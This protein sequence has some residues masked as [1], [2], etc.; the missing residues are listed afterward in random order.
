MPRLELGLCRGCCPHLTSAHTAKDKD[1]LGTPILTEPEPWL[2]PGLHARAR[3][4]T[5]HAQH[6]HTHAGREHA[7]DSPDCRP[8]SLL[9]APRA[10]RGTLLQARLVPSA[11]DKPLPH[12]PKDS[13][14]HRRAWRPS[15]GHNPPLDFLP[16]LWKEV[17]GTSLLISNWKKKS[18]DGPLEAGRG[19]PASPA[20]LQADPALGTAPRHPQEPQRSSPGSPVP[21]LCPLTRPGPCVWLLVPPR[22]GPHHTR[23]LHPWPLGRGSPCSPQVLVAEAGKSPCPCVQARGSEGPRWPWD[24]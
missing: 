19:H 13:S 1:A 12:L 3:T 23:G 21:L 22:P 5:A 11:Q 20:P 8:H 15:W 24:S 14:L 4:H 16:W 18:W 7:Q 17:T 9:S 10:A 2:R 6:T